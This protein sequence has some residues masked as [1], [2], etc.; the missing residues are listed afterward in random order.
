MHEQRV[1]VEL[2]TSIVQ[3][4]AY[5]KHKVQVRAA[6][7]GRQQ[8]D[9]TGTN[10]EPNPPSTHIGGEPSTDDSHYAIPRTS[11]S[12]IIQM[13]RKPPGHPRAERTN[14]LQTI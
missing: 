1:T 5:V 14:H 8:N 7:N 11:T 9:D 12:T 10:T 2:I 4:S 3:A 13:T 6:I